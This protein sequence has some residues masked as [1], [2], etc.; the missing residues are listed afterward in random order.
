MLTNTISANVTYFGDYNGQKIDKL[1]LSNGN[2]VTV[3]ALSFGATLYEI[4]SPD[5][6]GKLSNIVLNYPNAAD[7]LQNPF[8]VSMAIGRTG[9]RIKNAELEL[10]HKTYKLEANEG[11]ATLHGG[12][13]GFNTHIWDSQIIDEAGIPAI[14]FH[15]LQ[16]HSEDQFPGDIDVTI[17][18][19]LT[20]DNTVKIE[21]AATALNEDTVFNPTYHTYFNLGDSDTILDHELMVDADTHLAFD[22]NKLPTGEF[23]DVDNSPFDFRKPTSLGKAIEVMQNTKEKGF[24][25]IFKI[26]ETNQGQGIAV[27]SDPNS[28][29]S[30][31]INSDRNGLVVFTANS[32]THDHMNLTKTNGLG[33]PYEGVAL[34][35]QNLP[36]ATRFNDFGDIVLP[37]G[38]TVAHEIDYHIT[39]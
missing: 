21:L 1:S 18:Y 5:K 4:I 10:N 34:E 35:A 8:Y 7:Y 19:R 29:R 11:T 3:S 9:G 25:D 27:L 22:A 13:H 26:N 30:V 12:P 23:I 6:Q 24:D 36:D 14:Q 33:M 20:E 2:N 37:K 17:T 15:R 32:F 28:G 31:T 38:D 39:F 16:R